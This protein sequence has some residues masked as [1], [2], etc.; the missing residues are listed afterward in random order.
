MLVEIPD[1]IYDDVQALIK[2]RGAAHSASVPESID[3]LIEGDPINVTVPTMWQSAPDHPKTFLTYITVPEAKML[4]SMGLGYS[5]INGRWKQHAHSSGIPS[6][7]GDCCDGGDPDGMV[8]WDGDT[9]GASKGYTD[10]STDYDP[11]GNDLSEF[12]QGVIDGL[13]GDVNTSMLGKE[14][15]K[16]GLSQLGDSLT[17]NTYAME[18]A[19]KMEQMESLAKELGNIDGLK[20]FAGY[21]TKEMQIQDQTLSYLNDLSGVAE[22]EDSWNNYTYEEDGVYTAVSYN[23]VTGE[24]MTGDIE[25]LQ[26]YSTIGIDGNINN[27]TVDYGTFTTTTTTW[28]PEAKTTS[29]SYNVA[30]VEW[31]T[32]TD[33]HYT[34]DGTGSTLG[35]LG[36][37]Y[38]DIKEFFT[39]KQLATDSL[40]AGIDNTMDYVETAINAYITVTSIIDIANVLI[41]IEDIAK[42]YKAGM[43]SNTQMAR[44]AIGISIEAYSVYS[45]MKA[46]GEQSEMSPSEQFMLYTQMMSQDSGDGDGTSNTTTVIS[47]KWPSQLQELAS[48]VI[49]KLKKKF[50]V[51]DGVKLNIFHEPFDQ[52]A[53]GKL[54][55]I[56]AAGGQLFQAHISD[57]MYTSGDPLDNVKSHIDQEFTLM[58]DNKFIDIHAEYSKSDRKHLLNLRNKIINEYNMELEKYKNEY[59][60]VKKDINAYNT[61]LELY[62]QASSDKNEAYNDN[63]VSVNA[64]NDELEI[65]TKDYNNRVSS[66]QTKIDAYTS[67]LDTMTEDNVGWHNTSIKDKRATID[68]MEK[69]KDDIDNETSSLRDLKL[70]LD[71]KSGMNSLTAKAAKGDADAV[72]DLQE[73]MTNEHD[74]LLKR[75]E[76]LAAR[77]AHIESIQKKLNILSTSISKGVS[78]RKTIIDHNDITESNKSAEITT[79]GLLDAVRSV[80]DVL[81][82]RQIDVEMVDE[83]AGSGKIVVHSLDDI[84]PTIGGSWLSA[85]P[86]VGGASIS[87]DEQIDPGVAKAQ[88]DMLKSLNLAPAGYSMHID[89]NNTGTAFNNLTW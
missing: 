36:E 55:M 30:G 8:G 10:G 38:M 34:L 89:M 13:L 78:Y 22:A 54:Y 50:E 73:A 3:A 7:N 19:A 1:D 42:A 63:A 81:N 48:A 87:T 57:D 52:M 21:E 76:S 31:S 60:I 29:T 40:A 28:G 16:L 69:I 51:P 20:S 64:T 17:L 32:T 25:G 2:D 86:I 56:K 45:T 11:D 72:S 79:V 65:K 23:S 80:T 41:N 67:T 88:Y 49:T 46:L 14:D 39:G 26:S 35:V 15:Y 71:I 37:T 75:E 24:Y 84:A 12:Q 59:D 82:E 68:R 74:E 18:T 4:R 9:S 33:Q 66:L 53:G 85:G 44:M 58:F 6:F 43:I 62:T 27:N 47:S 70:E 77:K 5:F 61:E 83:D